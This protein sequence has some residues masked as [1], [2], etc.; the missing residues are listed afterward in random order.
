VRVAL[1]D[2][3]GGVHL[4]VHHRHDPQVA[5]RRIGGD[6][7]RRGEVGRPF[8]ARLGR[9]AHRAGHHHRLGQA[10]G[11]FLEGVGA[12]GDD[13]ARRAASEGVLDGA[14]DGVDVGQGELPRGDEAE[15]PDLDR[16]DAAEIR[17]EGD[18]LGA[19]H[20]R[21]GRAAARIDPAG[22]GSPGGDDGDPGR[23]G[24]PAPP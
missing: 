7:D 15:L 24:S 22:D 8:R 3:A 13:G 12:L 21:D 23:H 17:D 20:D 4:V 10:E 11:G 9:I 1:G 14:A 2:V 16:G 19:G 6:A 5:G 18:Q